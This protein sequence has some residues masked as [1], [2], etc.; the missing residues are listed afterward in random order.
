MKKKFQGLR[1]VPFRRAINKRVLWRKPR[2]NPRGGWINHSSMGSGLIWRCGVNNHRVIWSGCWKALPAFKLSSDCVAKETLSKE[3]SLSNSVK[4]AW[5][6]G[7]NSPWSRKYLDGESKIQSI[8]IW[9][10]CFAA[11]PIEPILRRRSRRSL[12]TRRRV[13]FACSKLCSTCQENLLWSRGRFWLEAIPG[14][15]FSLALV[16]AAKPT[17]QILRRLS[18]RRPPTLREWGSFTP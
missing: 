6:A 17:N 1:L 10:R 18:R 4:F 5:R 2:P 9:C 11:N 14:I 8:S 7:R 13:G 15:G 12:P 16:L 3:Q